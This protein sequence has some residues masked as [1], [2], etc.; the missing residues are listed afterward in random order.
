[1]HYFKYVFM[2][3]FANLYF[4]VTPLLAFDMTPE[5][6]EMRDAVE[7]GNADLAVKYFRD[8]KTHEIDTKKFSEVCLYAVNKN[9]FNVLIKII[10]ALDANFI[11]S[12]AFAA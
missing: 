10:G 2:F 6:K 9:Y 5:K 12:D 1:M 8:T 3:L 7:D 11:F 4:T